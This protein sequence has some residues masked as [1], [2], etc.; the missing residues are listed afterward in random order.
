MKSVIAVLLLASVPFAAQAA[1]IYRWTDETGRVNY[2]NVVPER[3]KRVATRVDTSSQVVSVQPPAV[4]A[5]QRGATPFDP[6]SASTGAG[7]PPVT[8]PGGVGY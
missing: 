1:D 4:G 2:G 3:F 6:P 8:G 7:T 5:T